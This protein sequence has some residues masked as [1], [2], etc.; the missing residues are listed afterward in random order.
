MQL[1]ISILVCG[2]QIIDFVC[3]PYMHAHF[4]LMIGSVLVGAV[5]KTQWHV[6]GL[7]TGEIISRVLWNVCTTPLTKKILVE[8]VPLQEHRHTTLYPSFKMRRV[9]LTFPFV[10]FLFLPP[11][12]LPFR[13][14]LPLIFLSPATGLM[15]Y[16]FLC[17]QGG[18]ILSTLTSVQDIFSLQTFLLLVTMAAVALLPG[19]LAKQPGS[20]MTKSK[21]S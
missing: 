15:P 13:N 16:N 7:C 4:S 10:L 14:S 3:M 17:C 9:S 12:H 2:S 20:P 5:G 18:L 19:L 21:R 6:H 1:P 8:I 11:P